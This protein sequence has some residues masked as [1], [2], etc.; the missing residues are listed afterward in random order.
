M[1]YQVRNKSIRQDNAYRVSVHRQVSTRRFTTINSIRKPLEFLKIDGMKINAYQ[2][3]ALWLNTAMLI[4][5]QLSAK[6]PHN[7]SLDSMGVI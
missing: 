7:L 4:A 5:N 1:F 6:C 3:P 2:V